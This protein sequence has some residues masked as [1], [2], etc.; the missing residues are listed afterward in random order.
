LP[1]SAVIEHSAG[2][3]KLL[4]PVILSAAF[5]ASTGMRSRKTPPE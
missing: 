5:A 2:V 4:Y 3:A 1:A